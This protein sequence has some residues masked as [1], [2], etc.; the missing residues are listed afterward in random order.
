LLRFACS[1]ALAHVAD[2]ATLAAM[3]THADRA[4]RLGAVL[5]LREASSDSLVA[6]LD[7]ADVQVAIE[8]ARAAYDRGA[9]RAGR[10]LA[11]MLPTA[12]ADLRREP[13]LRR[14]LHAALRSGRAE[15]AVLVA[16]FVAD[17]ATTDEWREEGL[18]VLMQWDEPDPR[19]GVWGRW[20]PCPPRPPGLAHEAVAGVL[21]RVFEVARGDGLSLALDL[22]EHEKI[23]IT[24]EAFLR[25]VRDETVDDELRVT[26]LGWLRARRAP[27]AA[28]AERLALR[29]D[30]DTLFLAAIRDVYPRQPQL[31]MET[32]DRVLRARSTAL[33]VRQAAVRSLAW[34][35]TP[36]AVSRLAALW[37]E[38]QAGRLDPALALD[39]RESSCR[40]ADRE[41]SHAARAVADSKALAGMLERFRDA[42]R[43]GDVTRGQR[44]FETHA[45]AACLRCHVMDG[46]GGATGPDLTVIGAHDRG[47]LLEALV[48]PPARLAPGYAATTMPAMA[49]VLSEFELRDLVEFLATRR[50]EAPDG[51]LATRTEA[52]TRGRFDCV[53]VDRACNGQPLSVAGHEVPRGVGV[54]APSRLVYAVPAGSRAF[55]GLAGVDDGSHGGE[56]EFVVNVNGRPAWRS[57]A[58]RVGR[59][60]RIHVPL[61]PGASSLE[62]VVLGTGGGSLHAHADWLEVGFVRE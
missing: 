27:E 32:V 13:W 53:A 17:L 43:G 21:E 34:S 45:E 26:A 24:N 22:A 49:G 57:G 51:P 60:V 39:V 62:L 40:S 10:A 42:L 47:E 5:A 4:V 33:P 7:D 52:R 9:A 23:R 37:R 19:E 14:A 6:F 58:V 44:V 29:S 11:S 61:G 20:A 36:E 12:R 59:K 50:D 2:P 3:R 35:T 1:R 15:D 28:V 16:R 30:S 38:Y 48:D 8:A 55:V 31:A 56:V 41:L 18:R 25:W 54:I 46:R